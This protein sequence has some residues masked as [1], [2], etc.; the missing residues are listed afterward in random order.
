[1]VGTTPARPG[2]LLVGDAA[3]LVN[4]LQG[5]GIAQ[6]MASGHAAADAILAR[7]PSCAGHQYRRYLHAATRHHRVNA[8]VH[9]GMI[10]HPLAVSAAGRILTAPLIRGAVAGAWGLYW[11]DLASDALPGQPR[12]LARGFARSVSH[13]RTAPAWDTKAPAVSRDG[14]LGAACVILHPESAFGSVRTGP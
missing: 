1:M 2:V 12:R 13:S 10:G 5:E 7:G 14:D 3:G 6:A 4:P 11:N 9:V 8:P